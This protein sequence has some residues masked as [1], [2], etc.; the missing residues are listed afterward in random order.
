MGMVIDAFIVS[1]STL[2]E[3][4]GECFPAGLVLVIIP[5]GILSFSEYL[6]LESLKSDYFVGGGDLIQK[7]E[8][9]G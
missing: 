3:E 8:G 1:S 9:L 2:T 6:G 4:F 7:S 5:S